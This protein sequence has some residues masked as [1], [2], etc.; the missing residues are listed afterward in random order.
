M[1]LSD[2]AHEKAIVGPGVVEL[3]HSGSVIHSTATKD[4]YDTHS[5]T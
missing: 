4:T 1:Q 3:F 2:S 5:G